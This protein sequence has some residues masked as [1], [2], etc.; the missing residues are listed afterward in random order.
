MKIVLLKDVKSIGKKGDIVTVSDG[1][2]SNYLIPNKLAIAG[3]GKAIN[4]ANQ[5][6]SAE[7]YHKEQD[8]LKAVELGNQLKDMTVTLQVKS[9]ENG[10]IFGSVTNKEVA[11]SLEKQ[12]F[13]IDKKKIDLAII[14][15]LGT[16]TAKIKL[17]PTVS[18]Q[19][20]VVVTAL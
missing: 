1:Y 14:K 8:R 15:S 11:T 16:Y 4:E 18:V 12:G 13:A 6:K 17:H 19:I 3:D 5:A 7:A 2:A 9:G 10:K 20:T